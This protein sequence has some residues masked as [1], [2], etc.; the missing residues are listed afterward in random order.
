[1]QEPQYG[2]LRLVPDQRVGYQSWEYQGRRGWTEERADRE[3]RMTEI[4]E[5][6]CVHELVN[7]DRGDS[8]CGC[9]PRRMGNVG[10][11]SESLENRS[12]A[13]YTGRMILRNVTAMRH[14][15]G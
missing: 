9:I 6:H 1:M 7:G 12:W 10:S 2:G 8:V 14:L 13:G 11:S 15:F 3:T 5:T 4:D